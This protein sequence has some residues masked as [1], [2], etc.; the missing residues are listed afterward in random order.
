M[1]KEDIVFGR[2]P[3]MELLKSQNRTIQ[4]LSISKGEN[5]G[6]I[7]KIIGIANDRGIR[8]EYIDKKN[9]DRV[10]DGGNH[11]GVVAYVTSYIY[12]DIEDIFEEAQKKEEAPFILILD[13]LEDI[14]NFGAIIRTAEA[15]G[16]HGI[17]IPERR[18]VSVNSSVA[19]ASAGA[20]EF[21]NIVKVKNLNDTI[22]EL[23]SR[24]LWIYGAD[25]NGEY[26]SKADLKGAIGLVIGNEGKGMSRLVK[27][28]CDMMLKIPMKGKINSLNASVA[29]G[30]L[31]YEI[32]NQRG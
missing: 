4:R 14:H 30:I 8:I 19:K 31:I 11:Q 15:A 2:N 16:V 6:S 25:M 13:N 20:V 12:K 32:V 17:I 10:A 22:R 27:E 28:N 29:S 21:V 1:S 23:K 18:S 9:L 5:K 3:V 26:Y 7:N 24:G